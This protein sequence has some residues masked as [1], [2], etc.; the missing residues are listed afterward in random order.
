[1]QSSR[2]S[3]WPVRPFSPFPFLP[4]DPLLPFGFSGAAGPGV[5]F[6]PWLPCTVPPAR[7]APAP[8]SAQSASEFLLGRM[9][10][11]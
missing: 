11:V 1:M 4:A 6:A 9:S 5:C 7:S 2:S 8:G 3:G 10:Q